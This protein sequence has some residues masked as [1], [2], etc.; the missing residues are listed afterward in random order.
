MGDGYTKVPNK[1]LEALMRSDLSR[2]QIAIVLFVIR[3]TYGFNK[4]SKAMSAS[5]IS[6][7]TGLNPGWVKHSLAELVKMGVLKKDGS[8]NRIRRLMVA[9]PDE[10][11]VAKVRKTSLS[12]SEEKRTRKVRK[13]SLL[14]V[15]KP[16]LNKDTLYDNCKKVNI[17]SSSD[18]DDE[19]WWDD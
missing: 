8:S 12:E 4:R 6:N 13:T 17:D 1:L 18:E 9:D 5:Y 2:S 19:R 11:S 16:H 15:V 7:G 3:S 14:G 10:W